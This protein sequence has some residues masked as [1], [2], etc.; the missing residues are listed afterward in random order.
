MYFCFFLPLAVIYQCN[1]SI[2]EYHNA[3]NSCSSTRNILLCPNNDRAQ[4]TLFQD[5]GQ[6]TQYTSDHAGYSR[7]I[8]IK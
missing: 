7:I 1:T 5:I 6:T 2:A 4:N 3:E 8:D